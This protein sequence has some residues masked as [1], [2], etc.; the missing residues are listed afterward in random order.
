[1][2]KLPTELIDDILSL[3]PTKPLVRFQC[4]SKRWYA[5]INGAKFIK[6][7]LARSIHISQERILVVK[8]RDFDRPQSYFS[9]PFP[10]DD[11]FGS[12][13]KIH[14][15]LPDPEGCTKIVGYC[16]GLVCIQDLEE[17]IVIWNPLIRKYKKLPFEPIQ[18][19]SGFNEYCLPQFAFGHDPINDDY[20]VFRVVEFYKTNEVPSAFEVKAYSLRAHSWRRVEDEWPYEKSYICSNPEALSSASLN[21]ILHWLVTPVTDGVH[22]SQ[23]LVGFDL[24]TEKFRVYTLPVQSDCNAMTRMALE[25]WGGRILLCVCKDVSMGF[26][27]VWVMKEYGVASSWTRLYTIVHGE[28][29]WNFNHCK[30]LVISKDG[31]KVLMEHD[32]K[33]LFWYDIRKKSSRRVKIQGMPGLFQTVTCVGSLVLLHGYNCDSI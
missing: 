1:M 20:M 18:K 22:L 2:S 5:L 6:K 25:V 29:P 12:A 17:E 7:H 30:P 13:V 3:L 26:N 23:T 14:Q 15:P 11:R 9:V 16:N 24:A 8:E 33:H 21:G 32:S 27:E 19:P 28:V 31:N 10:E 4:V